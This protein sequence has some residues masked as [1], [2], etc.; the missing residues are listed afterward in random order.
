VR[1]GDPQHINEF[2]ESE[3]IHVCQLS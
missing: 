2:V 1:L 3:C